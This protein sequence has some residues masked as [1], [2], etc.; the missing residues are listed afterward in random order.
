[1]KKL[2]VA[3]SAFALFALAACGSSQNSTSDASGGSGQ[4]SDF[5]ILAILAQSGP[6]SAIGIPVLNGINAAV[7]VLNESGGIDGHKIVL[8]VKDDQGDGTNAVSILISALNSG[9]KPEV[10]FD[11]SETGET[12]A[13]EP[14]LTEN[15]ILSLG[16]S[17]DESLADGTKYPYLFHISPVISAEA[18]SLID[19]L[20]SK[21]YKNVGLFTGDEGY[22]QSIQGLYS[23]ALTKAG[24]TNE[25]VTY[26]ASALDLTSPL[27]KLE[28]SKPD[29]IL[30]EGLGPAPARIIQ[31]RENAGISTPLLGE[32]GVTTNVYS[33]VNA[34]ARQGVSVFTL[35]AD[36]WIPP[37][38][39]SKAWSEFLAAAASTPGLGGGNT[40][41]DNI[42]P[43][44]ELQLVALAAKQAGSIDPEAIKQALENLKQP[45]DKPYLMYA[46]EAFTPTLHFVTPTPSDFTVIPLSP[47]TSDGFFKP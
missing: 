18:N 32:L 24:I 37:A 5:K 26:D 35:K 41:Y 34:A 1:V 28:A 20:K 40:H 8:I 25:S 15:K 22:G 7:K 6:E 47:V 23:Q 45:A 2:T 42:V 3:V 31:A 21:G 39:R 43:W 46:T 29:V 17:G 9:D 30:F 16:D 10:V 27:E 33:Q 36:V 4:S 11:G 44:D 19:Y 38:Q 13:L 14:L 12:E